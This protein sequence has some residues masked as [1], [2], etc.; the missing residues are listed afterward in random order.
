MAQS[1]LSV[2]QLDVVTFTYDEIKDSNNDLSEKIKEAFGPEGYGICIVQGVPGY[3]EARARLLP[4]APRLADLPKEKLEKYEFPKSYYA[5]GWSHG[6]EK[7]SGIRDYSKGSF[8]ANPQYDNIYPEGYEV[9]DGDVFAPNVWPKEELPELEGAFKDLGCL[10]VSTGV[11]LSRHIDDYI[12]KEV[13]TFEKGKIEDIITQSKCCK[14]RLLHYFPSNDE[15]DADND[16]CGWHNDHGTLTGLCSAMYFDREGHEIDFKDPESGLFI[17]K[18]S[19]EVKKAAIPKD[20]LAFQIGESTQIHSG[21]RVQATP[22][23]VIRGPK[24]IGTGI[25]RDT[26]AVFMQPNKEGM[27]DLPKNIKREDVFVRETTK[28]PKLQDRWHEKQDFDEF[29]TVTITSYAEKPAEEK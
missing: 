22:H 7:F 18:R 2:Q 8:Y 17:Q 1:T 27:M 28:V 15:K 20:C 19:D 3:V 5:I 9:Q 29:A 16:W 12:K 23:A 25:C 14:A 13:P 21:G 26:F 24:L 10:I 6:K 11:L 4:L